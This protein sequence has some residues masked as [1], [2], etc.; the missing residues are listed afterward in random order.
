MEGFG[1]GGVGGQGAEGEEWRGV[2][3]AAV[4]GWGRVGEGGTRLCL[5]SRYGVLKYGWFIA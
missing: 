4:R 2:W 5:L 3:V 1:V